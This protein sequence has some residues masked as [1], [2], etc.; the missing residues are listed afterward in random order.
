MFKKKKEIISSPSPLSTR[1][2]AVAGLLENNCADFNFSLSLL[3]LI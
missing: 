2:Y 3:P 1:L